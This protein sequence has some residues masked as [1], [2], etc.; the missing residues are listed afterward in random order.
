MKVHQ[1]MPVVYNCFIIYM[2]D[3]ILPRVDTRTASNRQAGYSNHD[4]LLMDIQ[5]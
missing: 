4:C 1:L 3:K 2:Q 5:S